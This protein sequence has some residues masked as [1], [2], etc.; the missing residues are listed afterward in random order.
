[1]ARV[2]LIGGHGKIALQAAPLLAADGHTVDAVIRNPDQASDVEAAQAN[3]VVADV[4]NLDTDQLV[5]LVDGHD[6]VVW[7]AGAGGGDPARTYAVDRDA[8]IRS[9]DA[10]EQAGVERYLMVSY[11]GAG[12]DHGVP[13]D[14]GF[15]H[16]AEAKA[17]AD[18]H[19]RDSGLDWVVLGP[20]RLTDDA[21]TG[22]VSV[23]VP[24]KSEVP[25]ADVAGVI[26]AAVA[27]PELSRVTYEF[28]GGDVPVTEAV[29]QAAAG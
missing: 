17:A 7:S 16:Y 20:S 8:A 23:D 25:R 11:F 28:N 5:A 3:P 26:A 12:P 21:A 10:A 14:V 9:I 18:T 22:Q 27:N 1:M 4:E 19:L 13:E 29:R 2:L 6:V 15:F 24:E